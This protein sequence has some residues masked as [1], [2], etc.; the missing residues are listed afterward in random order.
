MWKPT[1]IAE[2]KIHTLF[3]VL[4]DYTR[5]IGTVWFMPCEAFHFFEMPHN[6]FLLKKFHDTH[7]VSPEKMII[8]IYIIQHR[9]LCFV[10]PTASSLLTFTKSETRNWLVYWGNSKWKLNHQI[11]SYL[12]KHFSNFFLWDR[13]LATEG[14][15]EVWKRFG[16]ASHH[17]RLFCPHPWLSSLVQQLGLLPKSLTTAH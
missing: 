2:G 11:D 17:E 8:Y 10:D 6:Y 5:K 9:S 4:L 15:S 12:Y 14:T 3:K 13:G 7:R 1:G 16:E